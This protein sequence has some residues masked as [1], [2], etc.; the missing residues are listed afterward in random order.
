MTEAR[1]CEVLPTN[2]W[3][4][5]EQGDFIQ[6]G[7]QIWYDEGNNGHP[8]LMAVVELDSGEVVEVEPKRLRFI[9]A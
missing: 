9:K 4:K 2:E 8:R 5:P 1:R 3:G 6:Y 7:N